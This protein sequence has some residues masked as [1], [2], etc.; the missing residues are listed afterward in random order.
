MPN[1][2]NG[3]NTSPAYIPYFDK[4]AMLQLA[5]QENGQRAYQLLAASK[6]QASAC[7]DSIS[8]LQGIPK[9]TI[10]LIALQLLEKGWHVRIFGWLDRI[11][12]ETPEHLSDCLIKIAKSEY[13]TPNA[14][15]V[16]EEKFDRKRALFSQRFESFFKDFLLKMER[17]GK[18]DFKMQRA[19]GMYLRYILRNDTKAL[20][21]F[22]EAIEVDEDAGAIVPFAQMLMEKNR[23]G[24][25]K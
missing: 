10:E 17:D 20:Q 4:A 5:A 22:R 12:N 7:L 9:E 1:T 6:S 3:D 8:T 19:Y 14:D 23:V 24:A 15:G 11:L 25:A 13:W 2:G 16:I 21:S 18:W